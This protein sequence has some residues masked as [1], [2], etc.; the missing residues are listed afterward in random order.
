MKTAVAKDARAIGY[1]GIG[2]IDSSVKAPKLAGMTATQENA[3]NGKSSKHSATRMI[4]SITRS[5]AISIAGGKAQRGTRTRQND[6]PDEV[7]DKCHGS[8]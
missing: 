4:S 1:V 7:H 8:G 2:H 6:E 3:A 5:M